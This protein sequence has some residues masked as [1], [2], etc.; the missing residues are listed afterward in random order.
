MSSIINLLNALLKAAE[1]F[2]LS[3]YDLNNAYDFLNHKEYGLSFDTIITQLY[4][5]GVEI[6]DDFYRL[7]SRIAKEMNLPEENYIFTKELI[8]NK[9]SIPRMVKEELAKL[10]S[11]LG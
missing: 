11:S 5:Y 8:R 3:K 7:I 9:E 10:I 4:E 2:G 1:L 6:D